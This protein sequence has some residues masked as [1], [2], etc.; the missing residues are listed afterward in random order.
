MH[1]GLVSAV[2]LVGAMLFASVTHAK[3]YRWLDEHGHVHYGDHVPAKYAQSEV[4]VLNEYGVVIGLRSELES[5]EEQALEES[6]Q[7]AQQSADEQFEEQ[8]RYDHYLLSSYDSADQIIAR[9]NDQLA[10]LDARIAIAE[11][12]LAR[13]RATL[14]ELRQRAD[15]ARRTDQAVP[16]TLQ[17][18]LMEFETMVRTSQVAV[19]AMHAERAKVEAEFERDVARFLELSS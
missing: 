15:E 7:Q 2:A 19:N 16:E 13:T 11:Q 8:Q 10:I 1:I 12:S 5:A 9:R 17:K 3:T 4:Q 14:E 6:D 18:Q